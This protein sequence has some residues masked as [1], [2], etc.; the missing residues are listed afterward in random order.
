M[1]TVIAAVVGLAFVASGALAQDVKVEKY[2]LANGMT[3]ILHE[4]RSLPVATVNTWYRVGAQDEPA[5]RSGFAHLFEH[6]MFM[7]TDRVPGSQFDVLMETGGGANN[8][9]TDL[10]RTNYYSWGPSALLPTLLWLDADRLEA[11][12]ATMNTMKVDRQRDVVRNELRQS[13]ENAPYGKA[14]EMLWKMMFPA[15]HPYET[16]V[17]GTHEDLEAASVVNVKDFF[18]NFYVPSNASLVV[19]GDFDSKEIKPLIEK[20]FGTLPPGAAVTRKYVRPTEP[21]PLKLAGVKRVTALDKVELAKV[22]YTYHSPVAFGPGDAEM[23]LAAGVLARGSSSRLYRRLVIDEKLASEVSASQSGYPLGSLFQV[24]ALVKPGTDLDRVEKVMDEELAKFVGEGPSAEE[25]DRQKATVELGLLQSLQ[26]IERK[27]DKLNEYEYYWGEPNSFKRDLERYRSVDGSAVKTWAG[28]VLTPGA[29][30]IVRVLPEKPAKVASGRDERPPAAAAGEL[31]L[32]AAESFTTGNGVKVY[33]WRR[34]E[35]P[36]VAMRLV[37]RPGAGGGGVDPV[38]KAG[39]ASLAVQ[40]MEEGSGDLDA[41]RFAEEVQKIG[42]T[43]GTQS[44]QEVVGASMTVLK[45]NVGRGAELFAGAVQRPRM[46]EKDFERAKRLR[47]AALEQRREDPRSSAGVVGSR[48]LFGDGNAYGMPAVGVVS[49]VSPLTL[50]EVKSAHARLLRPETS[51]LLLAGDLTV[52]EAKKTAETIVGGWKA[53]NDGA[54]EGSA[55]YATLA[56]AAAGEGL[57][58]ALVDRPGAV[59][60]MIAFYAPGVKYADP[61]RVQRRVLNTI[62]GGMF[63]SRL[64]ANLREDKGYTYGARSRQEMNISAGVFTA[65]AAVN[66]EHTGDS[67][68]EFFK[69]FDR[70]RTG[71]VAENEATK[72]RETVRNETVRGFQGLSGLLAAGETQ[73]MNGLPLETVA[74]DLKATGAVSAADLNALT[75]TAV[76]A[77]TGEKGVL[78]LV[79]D[80]ALIL[81]QIKDLKLPT[82]V[83][84]DGEGKGK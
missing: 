9:S 50:A 10:H 56:R 76:P 5:R 68:K 62:L 12:G 37:S 22:Q 46:E 18:A 7:G 24:E 28:K 45:R 51:V 13:V 30:A 48:L 6:L 65:G 26:S 17:I 53:G 52:E 41:V 23:D 20:L 40:M 58:V 59:Q 82:P 57:R 66:A 64:N 69:E 70:I 15:G 44:D 1:R 11:V 8:A 71:D 3:V 38:G 35:L 14:S 74:V 83:E 36:L 79:G 43:F 81:E 39:L 25:L 2:V 77:G 84:F 72:G 78:V 4:D 73:L 34:T 21:M 31:S 47:L 60:T 55:A 19:A 61:T 75:K 32:P 29:R 49:T 67:L 27:A 42:A 16:G 33:S 54:N 63:T 80:K